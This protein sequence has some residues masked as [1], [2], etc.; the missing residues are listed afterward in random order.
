M[1]NDMSVEEKPITFF[2]LFV[3]ACLGYT[4]ATFFTV[5]FEEDLFRI[6]TPFLAP[7]ILLATFL[8]Y[9]VLA[10]T[11]ILYIP[12]QIKKLV[13]RVFIPVIINS[14]TFLTVYYFYDSIKDFR[15]EIGFQINKNRFNQAASWVSQSIQNGGLDLEEARGTVIL[16]KEYKN[17]A[18][19][20]RVLVTN[21]YGVITILFFRGGG[22]FEYGPSFVYRSDN[23]ASGF[24]IYGDIQCNK[25]LSPNW[26]DCY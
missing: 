16:P 14:A 9:L 2:E 6:F 24:E 15:I 25:W 3:I 4:I 11:S 13:W 5:F 26:Y 17:L 21:E 18:D 22:M 12:F 8:G 19:D 10:G 23:I 20:G 1:T 7:F